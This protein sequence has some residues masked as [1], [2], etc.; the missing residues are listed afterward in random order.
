MKYSVIILAGVCVLFFIIQLA[1]PSFTD[2]LIL[3]QTS[4]HQPWRFVASIFLHGSPSHLLYNMF[5]LILFGLILENIIGT[6]KFLLIFFLTGIFANLVAVNFYSSSLGASGAIFGIIGVLTILRPT[7]S[8]FAFGL[9]MPLFL[10][11]IIWVIGDIITT[12]VPSNIGTIAH[13]VGLFLG[14]LFGLLFMKNY[15][16]KRK[17]EGIKIP[18]DYMDRWENYYMK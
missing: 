18:D 14:I 13:L 4:F 1:I 2:A 5:A 7:M 17:R 3:D 12:F 9:P 6:K 11:S 10:A 8:I 15:S 16:A